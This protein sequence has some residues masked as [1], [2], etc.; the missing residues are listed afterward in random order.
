M[1]NQSLRF[2]GGFL[3]LL[4]LVACKTSHIEKHDVEIVD[5]RREV[6]ELQIPQSLFHR[7]E[8]MIDPPENSGH[9]GEH[10]AD[11]GEGHGE[12]KAEGGHGES[13]SGGSGA[14]T[15]NLRNLK[16][17]DYG[18]IVVYLG[19]KK[20]A[21]LRGK[22]LKIE[23]AKGGGT[24]DLAKYLNPDAPGEFMFGLEIMGTQEGQNLKAYFVSGSKSQKVGT[25]VFGTGCGKVADITG[26]YEK[27]LSK[28]GLTVSSKRAL[29]VS[30]LVGTYVLV[31]QAFNGKWRSAQVSVVDSSR[32]GMAC[33][34]VAQ[35][36]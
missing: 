29:H 11:K 32:P 18:E 19:S 22:Q 8:L 21:A 13:A 5:L 3:G 31:Y 4:V 17:M 24:V 14:A 27:E 20:G 25:D 7:L 23:F 2:T 34:R 6:A 30:Q 15:A 12:K 10:G 1:T 35:A 26:F 33:P 16:Q 28:Q 9:G 36:H